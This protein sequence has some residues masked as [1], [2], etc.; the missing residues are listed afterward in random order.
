V[1][2]EDGEG[3]GVLSRK[4]TRKYGKVFNKMVDSFNKDKL[5]IPRNGITVNNIDVENSGPNK[6]LDEVNNNL[7]HIRLKEEVTVI[8]NTTIIK[9]GNN[10]RIIKR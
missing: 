8:G 4:A 3:W 2:V 9:K 5:P 7:R 6:R 1:E 10:T